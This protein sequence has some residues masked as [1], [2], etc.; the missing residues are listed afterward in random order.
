M[1]SNNNFLLFF[2][3]IVESNTNFLAQS[4]FWMRNQLQMINARVF[5]E[6]FMDSRVMDAFNCFFVKLICCFNTLE[7]TTYVSNDPYDCVYIYCF[8]TP[9]SST[10]PVF[11]QSFHKI[12]FIYFFHHYN[13]HFLASG[14]QTSFLYSLF[15][16]LN[17]YPRILQNTN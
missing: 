5:Y 11:Y 2:I 8:L 4:A 9:I 14:S 17:T 7:L 16:Y 1:V 10:F 6:F 15:S 12:L 3:E 13:L